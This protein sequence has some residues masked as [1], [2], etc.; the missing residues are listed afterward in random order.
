MPF[1]AVCAYGDEV[2]PYW[3]YAVR[4]S[5]VARVFQVSTLSRLRDWA[6][7]GC[8]VRSCPAAAVDGVL[9]LKP[10]CILEVAV[11]STVERQKLFW[12]FPVLRVLPTEVDRLK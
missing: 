1:F 11:A 4:M 10:V 3:W 8:C 9:K 7:Y 12:G 2:A 6:V 5:L